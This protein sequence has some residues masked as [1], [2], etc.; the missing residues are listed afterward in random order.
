MTS[1]YE[2]AENSTCIVLENVKL[3]NICQSLMTVQILNTKESYD[4]ASSFLDMCP[5]RL[6]TCVQKRNVYRGIIHNIPLVKKR[7]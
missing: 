3:Y 6:K 1:V 2:D 7:T 5:S 4:L